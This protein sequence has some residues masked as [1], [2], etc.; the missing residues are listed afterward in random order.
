MGQAGASRLLAH[1]AGELWSSPPPGPTRPTEVES[2]VAQALMEVGLA[3]ADAYPKPLTSEIIETT[4]YVIMMGC[5]DAC[6]VVPGRHYLD[7][8][9]AD[10]DG[11]TIGVM[12]TT[13]GDITARITTPWPS[14][15]TPD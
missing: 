5:G 6:P 9:V 8:S 2:H 7:W 4:D 12:R 1:R 11:A 13:L 10:P 15:R 3:V 14:Y